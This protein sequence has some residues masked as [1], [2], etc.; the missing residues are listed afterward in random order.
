MHAVADQHG[1]HLGAVAAQA[2][3]QPDRAGEGER[4]VVDVDAELVEQGAELVEHVG[5]RGLEQ[6]GLA[7]EVVVERAEADVGGLGDLLDAG[8]GGGVAR[9]ASPVR[10][11]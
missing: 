4:G 2:Q 11:R 7:G 5:D 6:L 9:P 10:R 1:G 8:L 3:G